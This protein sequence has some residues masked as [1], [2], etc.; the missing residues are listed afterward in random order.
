MFSKEDLDAINNSQIGA[1]QAKLIS[2]L[3]TKYDISTE[4]MQGYVNAIVNLKAL[5]ET[6]PKIYET[7][8]EINQLEEE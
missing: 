8:Q 4:V 6:A 5:E 2:D 7:E 1:E 3:S